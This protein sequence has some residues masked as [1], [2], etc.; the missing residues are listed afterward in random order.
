VHVDGRKRTLKR[1]KTHL[2]GPNQGNVSSFIIR[3]IDRT[4]P[5]RCC[6]VVH[7]IK[8]LFGPDGS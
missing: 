7:N 2:D 1:T 8:D 6:G 3:Y 5:A 4:M